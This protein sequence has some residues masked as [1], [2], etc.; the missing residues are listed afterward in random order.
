MTEFLKQNELAERWNI[1]QRTLEKMR[2]IGEGPRYI[3]CG[4]AVRYRLSDIEQYENDRASDNL[5]RDPCPQ[6]TRAIREM[7]DGK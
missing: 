5:K 6:L 4:H 1:S 2:W 7:E 3:K